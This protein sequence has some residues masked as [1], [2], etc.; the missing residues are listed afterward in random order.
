MSKE[1]NSEADD[2]A[3]CCPADADYEEHSAAIDTAEEDSNTTTIATSK[4][5]RSDLWKDST[6]GQQATGG[7]ALVEK[8][9]KWCHFKNLLDFATLL[10]CCKDY[11]KFMPGVSQSELPIYFIYGKCYQCEKQ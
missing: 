10:C 6:V 8:D 1:H 7:G 11:A 4:S 2:M 3:Q 5:S 9:K